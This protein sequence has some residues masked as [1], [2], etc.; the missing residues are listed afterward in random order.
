MTAG[1]GA[2]GEARPAAPVSRHTAHREDVRRAIHAA[3]GALGPLALWLPWRG[4]GGALLGGL[5]VLAIVLETARR[6]SPSLQRLVTGAAGALFRPDEE[7]AL[8]GP[9]VLVCG[10]AAAWALF[11]PRTAAL[12]IVVAAVADPAAA[13]VGRRL[14]RGPGKSWAGS[15]ACAATAAVVIAAAGAGGLATAAGAVAAALAER[16]PWR[17]ADNLLVPVAVGAALSVVRPG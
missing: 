1:G 6:A 10:Y 3:S 12:A 11:S 2:A 13:L 8:S 16:A 4:A 15:A 7:R 5:A 14:A 9:T 17:G